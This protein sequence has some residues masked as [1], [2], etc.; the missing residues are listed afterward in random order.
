MS[1]INDPVYLDSNAVRPY[2]KVASAHED[3]LATLVVY[4]TGATSFSSTVNSEVKNY[5]TNLST[6][7]GAL[8]SGKIADNEVG[9][10][11]YFDNVQQVPGDVA[12]LDLRTEKDYYGIFNNFSVQSITESHDQIMKIHMNFG[13]RWNAFFLGNAPNVYTITGVLLDTVEYPYYQEFIVAYEKYLSGRKCIENNMQTKLMVNGQIIDGYLVRVTV[14]HSAEVQRLKQFSLT[15]LVT[16]TSWIR[17]NYTHPGVVGEVS[18]NQRVFNGLSNAN[19]L[20]L[21]STIIDPT[22]E[23]NVSNPPI[24]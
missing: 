1:F 17:Y 23:A 20:A 9:N 5:L 18:D 21:P 12:V 13:A 16:G 22:S 15:V 2:N 6:N 8:Q 7:V 19:R 3:G 11:V 24:G 10:S 4:N 14:I